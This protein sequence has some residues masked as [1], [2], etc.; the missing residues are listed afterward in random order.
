MKTYIYTLSHPITNEVRYV[1]KTVNPKQRKHNH[2]NVSRDKGTHKRNWINSLK[3]QGLRPKFEILDQVETDWKFWEKYWIS[4][5]KAW[6]FSLCN[7]TLGG[8]GLETSNQTSFKKGQKPW[9][10]GTAKP[11]ILKGN[12]GKTENSIKNQ[13]KP[14][15]IPW[16]KGSKGYSTSKKGQFLSETIKIKISNSLKGKESNKKRIIKQ[17]NKNMELVK[18]YPSITEAVLKTGIKSISNALTGRAKTA[19]GY[20]WL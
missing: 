3:L 18:E 12:V 20:I 15:F 4:Q 7:H 11:K 1:G 6:G 8:D 5:F 14:G 13:F 9:N 10:Y 16:N 2:S 17:Y 19:G